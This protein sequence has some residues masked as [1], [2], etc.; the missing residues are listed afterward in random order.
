MNSEIEFLIES[1]Q[2]RCAPGKVPNL[3]AELFFDFYE[4]QQRPFG[5]TPDPRY[6]YLS[7]SH[8]EALASLSYGF[9]NSQ[10]LMA[11][12]APPGF[13][14]T[15]LLI[16]FLEL[17]RESGATVF[18]FQTPCHPNKLFRCLLTELGV[19]TCGQDLLAMHEQLTQVLQR[20]KSL[21]KR[22][23]LVIDEAQKLSE[24]GLEAIRLLSQCEK[25][26]ERLLQIVLVGRP[27]LA[28]KLLKPEIAQLRQRIS[29]VATIAPLNEDEVSDYVENRLRMAGYKGS[30]IFTPAALDRIAEFSEGNPRHI[31]NLC[32]S[33]LSLGFALRRKWIDADLVDRVAA[34]LN[35][36]SIA[37][38]LRSKARVAA[39]PAP[40]KREVLARRSGAPVPVF[41]A[42][43]TKHT[44]RRSAVVACV[45]LVSLLA[46]VLYRD[47][48]KMAAAQTRK[49]AI[50]STA[51][52]PSSEKAVKAEVDIPTPERP[53]A[54]N[55]PAVSADT[56]AAL[57]A[58]DALTSSAGEKL[59]LVPEMSTVKHTTSTELVFSGET[60]AVIV[61]P[62]DD[63]RQICLRYLGSYNTR[64][65][66]E[67]SAL[68]PE[69]ADPD[70]IAV[71]QRVVL[72]R[73]APR[74]AG[75]SKRASVPTP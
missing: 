2:T 21:G 42:V 39:G 7:E 53:P 68:N 41:R 61:H 1:R 54:E 22:F 27:R 6:L 16:R 3:A 57:E 32:L 71:G 19:E 45:F 35:I 25:A 48:I 13:G 74:G 8:R 60:T 46:T 62:H 65:V 4:L 38:M 52:L 5:F 20:E 11:L 30:G 64:L 50:A 26:S 14:K 23:V 51:D 29:L 47:D 70:R 59:N 63:L 24:L 66:S 67:I 15:T 37:D 34:Y 69:L 33:S 72:P 75:I 18:L 56:A 10:G 9:T 40:A 12:V 31:N 36:D 55:S 44:F 17:M 73:S 58:S 28:E 43:G 49:T